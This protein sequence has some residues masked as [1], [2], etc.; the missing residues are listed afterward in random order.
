MT[1]FGRE[2]LLLE[3][4][5]GKF[6]INA[7]SNTSRNVPARVFTYCTAYPESTW[8]T[9]ALMRSGVF[10]IFLTTFDSPCFTY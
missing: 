8:Y 7:H 4:V 6:V 3:G 9:G 1:F 10:Q 2:E 5:I